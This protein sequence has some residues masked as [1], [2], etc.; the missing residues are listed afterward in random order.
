MAHTLNVLCGGTVTVFG[1]DGESLNRFLSRET[2]FLFAYLEP[3]ERLLERHRSGSDDV[4]QVLAVPA[5]LKWEDSEAALRAAAGDLEGLTPGAGIETSVRQLA[6]T[7][8]CHAAV[9][10]NDPL[11]RDKMQYLLEEL[12][13]TAHSSVCPHGRPVVLRMTRREIERNFQRI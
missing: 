7:M 4:L 2:Q 12:R 3:L 10:A 11:T 6:A 8:A 1:S 13:K 9:K 5:I